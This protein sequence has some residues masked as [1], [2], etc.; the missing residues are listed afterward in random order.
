MELAKV[1]F[2]ND[3]LVQCVRGKCLSE[4][5]ARGGMH[6]SGRESVVLQGCNDGPISSYRAAYNYVLT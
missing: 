5:Q 4:R 3:S 2:F 6:G 1:H